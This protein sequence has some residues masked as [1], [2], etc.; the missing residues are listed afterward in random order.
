M[1]K[2]EYITIVT[3]YK[4]K[5]ELSHIDQSVINLALESGNKAYAPYSNLK[6]GASV[7]LENGEIIS[8]NNQENTAYPSGMCAERVALFYANSKYPDIPIKT[9]AICAFNKTEMTKT[10]IF[11]CGSCRQVLLETEFRFNK[12]IKVIMVGSEKIVV[13]DNVIQLLPLYFKR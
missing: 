9:I 5:T 12:P 3:E 1:I 2:K 6:V 8:S 13:S 10:P 11:P 7:L 4:S